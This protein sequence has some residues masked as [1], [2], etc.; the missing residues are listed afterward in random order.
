MPCLEI[1]MPT[2]DKETKAKLSEELTLAFGELSGFDSEI[3]GILYN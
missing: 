1:S 3:F 2:L